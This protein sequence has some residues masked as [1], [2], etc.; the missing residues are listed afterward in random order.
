MLNLVVDVAL[1]SLLVVCGDVLHDVSAKVYIF[2]SV[3]VVIVSQPVISDLQ[4][5]SCF[6]RRSGSVK[7]DGLEGPCSR[8]KILL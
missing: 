5:D 8:L 7:F 3:N 2:F 4:P 1:L 6:V